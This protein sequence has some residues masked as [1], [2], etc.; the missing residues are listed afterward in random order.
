MQIVSVDDEIIVDARRIAGA[1][2][3]RFKWLVRNGEMVGVNMLFPFE[4]K[5]GHVQAPFPR[6][7]VYPFYTSLF[8]S[9]GS[10][11]CFIS[12]ANSNFQP[13]LLSIGT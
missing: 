6:L 11:A 1:A 8:R 2:F 10:L 3:V 5:C 7:N 13:L 4:F 9:I 12:L